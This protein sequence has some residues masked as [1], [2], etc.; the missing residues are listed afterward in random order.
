MGFNM[1]MYYG[2][3]LLF[4]SFIL[5]ILLICYMIYKRLK[6]ENGKYYLIELDIEQSAKRIY[7]IKNNR[8]EINA[9]NTADIRIRR[10][11]YDVI[12]N[13]EVIR[14]KVGES[15]IT[16][17]MEFKIVDNLTDYKGVPIIIG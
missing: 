4:S 10:G 7:A 3:L 9:D 11:F 5:V 2:L 14:R 6:S 1:H 15:F 17:N 13:D 12:N 16:D 8:I